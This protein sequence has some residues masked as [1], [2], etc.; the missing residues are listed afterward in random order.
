M[1]FVVA[2]DPPLDV[3]G[4]MFVLITVTPQ[5]FVSWPPRFSINRYRFPAWIDQRE[6]QIRDPRMIHPQPDLKILD[7]LKFGDVKGT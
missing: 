2:A 1:K 7:R 5:P 6:S 3:T 4:K